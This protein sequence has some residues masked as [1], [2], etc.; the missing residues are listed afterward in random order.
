MSFEVSQ[1][2]L[3]ETSHKAH[4]R[5][6]NLGKQ[7]QCQLIHLVR[8]VSIGTTGVTRVNFRYLNPI[9]TMGGRFCQPSQRS[10]TK[11]SLWLRP[12]IYFLKMI[13][14]L[15]DHFGKRTA[16]SLIYFLNYVILWYLAQSQ[17]L[18]ITLYIFIIKTVSFFWQPSL[19]QSCFYI[20]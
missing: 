9:P 4:V 1:A 19:L 20:K 16:W 2:E 5:T 17:I 18:G 14:L 3:T 12:R 6:L 11:F 7:K 15:G 8:D 13:L 10:K